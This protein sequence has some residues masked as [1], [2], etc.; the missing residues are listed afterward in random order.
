[1]TLRVTEKLLDDLEALAAGRPVSNTSIR[2]LS[3]LGLL[4][5]SK[6]T[7]V[8]EAGQTRKI[9]NWTFSEAGRQAIQNRKHER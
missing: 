3:K 5:Q 4:K 8:Y 7:K 9:L 2:A 6:T 1:M